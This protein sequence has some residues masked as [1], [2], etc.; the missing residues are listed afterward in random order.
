MKPSDEHPHPPD[1]DDPGWAE[2][3]H[4][5]FAPTGSGGPAGWVRLCLLPHEGLAHYWASLGGEGQPLVVVHD[6]EVLL[7]RGRAMEIRAE[8][9]WADHVVEAPF[10]Q[11]GVGC[12]AFGLR[13]DSVDDLSAQP[14]MGERVPFGL[15]LEWATGMAAP[16]ELGG[17]HLRGQ[18]GETGT[19]LG[20]QGG[21]AGRDSHHGSALVVDINR[22]GYRIACHVYG[23]ALVGDERLAIDAPGIRIH[24]WG[25]EPPALRPSA[26]ALTGGDYSG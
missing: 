26:A 25:G 2:W 1:P 8:G 5:H 14:L 22:T 13:L 16:E 3:W 10:E 7:P 20:T 17:R 18:P 21:A 12:E 11:V 4:F 23:E 15:D 19:R 6:D 9:L 24:G